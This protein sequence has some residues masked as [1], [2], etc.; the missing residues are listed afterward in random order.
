M[1]RP[2]SELK[3]LTT[4]GV[5]TMTILGEITTDDL[6]RVMLKAHIYSVRRG[7]EYASPLTRDIEDVVLSVRVAQRS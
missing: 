5:K 2:T 1:T 6:I 4:D 3:V 7:T